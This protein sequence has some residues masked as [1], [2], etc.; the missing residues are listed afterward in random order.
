[1]KSY[2]AVW[3]L[4]LFSISISAQTKKCFVNMGLKDKHTVYLTIDG[5]KVSGEFKVE[6]EYEK[7]T[8]FNF[9]GTNSNNNLNISFANGK[10]PYQLPPKS[11]KGVWML[12]KVGDAETLQVKIYG[13]NYETNKYSTYFATYESC[14]PSYETLF[15]KAKRISFAKGA[16]SATTNVTLASID[17]KKAF[18]LKLGKGQK[19]RVEAI[20]CGI[21]FYYPDK[22][23]YEEGTAIDMWG[24]DSLTQ[25]GDYLFVISPAG[26]QLTCNVNFKTL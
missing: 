14:D 20:G 1:M 4:L 22:T 16:T 5:A 19:F 17:D 10:S 12:K 9:S 2:L 24:S 8:V 15:K 6:K 25:S 7:T 23:E 11:T 13:K 21:S 3:L 18:L 26:T